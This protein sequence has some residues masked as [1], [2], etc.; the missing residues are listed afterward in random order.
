MQLSSGVLLVL[1]FSIV[2]LFKTA[3]G[4][5]G[6]LF[7]ANKGLQSFR[8]GSNT[9]P[10]LH[11]TVIVISTLR[12]SIPLPVTSK[13]VVNEKLSAEGERINIYK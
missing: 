8:L 12:V 9:S 10:N 1:L 6:S 3:I 5:F 4:T 2:V 7:S 11:L 13:K